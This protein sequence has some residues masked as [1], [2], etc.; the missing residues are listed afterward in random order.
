[1]I[2]LAMEAAGVT[3][4]RIALVTTWSIADRLQPGH[5]STLI[6]YCESGKAIPA[7]QFPCAT[8]QEIV[9]CF[10]FVEVARPN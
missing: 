6:P 3:H 9:E 4:Y 7:V 10:S 2:R 5:W 8:R 1:M